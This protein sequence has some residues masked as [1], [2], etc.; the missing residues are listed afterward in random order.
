M[1]TKPFSPYASTL[2]IFLRHALAYHQAGAEH[3]EP[4]K[5]RYDLSS[6]LWHGGTCTYPAGASGKDLI[7]SCRTVSASHFYTAVAQRHPSVAGWTSLEIVQKPANPAR[8]LFV[9]AWYAIITIDVT[10]MPT[11]AALGA[12]LREA[13]AIKSFARKMRW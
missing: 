1:A 2:A 5:I 3:G 12:A 10:R 8:N 9:T 7:S 11:G 13:I 4:L 6:G